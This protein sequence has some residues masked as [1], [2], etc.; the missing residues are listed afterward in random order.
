[1]IVQPF[2]GPPFIEGSLAMRDRQYASSPR[3]RDKIFSTDS[4]YPVEYRLCVAPR[5]VFLQ[6]REPLALTIKPSRLLVLNSE[7]RPGATL[8][9]RNLSEF[10]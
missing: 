6:H 5:I 10:S 1:L 8:L 4:N 9:C 3:S 2:A 7:H